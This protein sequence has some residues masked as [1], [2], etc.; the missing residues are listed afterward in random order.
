MVDTTPQHMLAQ[1]VAD[2]QE[3]ATLRMSAKAR[4]L[5]AKGID[6]I[7]LSLGEPDFDTP[8]H[9]KEAAVDALALGYTKYTPVTGLKEYVDAIITKF[10]R[11][12][13]LSYTP[14][15]ICVSNG[16][17]QS[18]SNILNAILNEGDEII[19][20]APYWVSYHDI[21]LLA[22][23]VPIEI[24]AGIETDF[25]V[26]AK[27]L[28]SAITH[29]TKAVLFSS[30]CNP[31]GSVY[32]EE[33]LLAISEVIKKHDNIV[34]ISD[35]IYEYIN[36]T[37]NHVSIGALP[38]MKNRTVT[39]NGMSKGFAMTGWRLGYIGGPQWLISACSKIQGQCTS[40]AASF[41]QKAAAEAL[42][43]D[44]GPTHEMRKAFKKRRDLM[45]EL[46]KEIPGLKV[47]IPE[48]AFYAFP[49][50]SYYFGKRKG[51]VV[52]DDANDF[53]EYILEAAHVAVVTGAAFGSPNCVRLSYAA[54]ESTIKTAIERIKNT[55]D[56]F[57]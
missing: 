44:M 31:T 9:I 5:K 10:E 55:L 53:S 52:I 3:S 8:E 13:G 27:Q 20:F 11:D 43:G 23:G 4:Q 7:S 29:K 22:G 34:V 46:L 21:T 35:E 45:V 2:M 18:I 41:S 42:L 40:G 39:V 54:S 26:T 28:E 37:G 50:V 24:S 25:K 48:G 19:I 36:Y 15:E 6:V 49:D 1:R 32:T 30:P 14:S 38:D 57:E 51:D 16:A 56:G 12:N 17:K 47:N 33:E